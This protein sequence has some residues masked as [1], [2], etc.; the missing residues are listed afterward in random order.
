MFLALLTVAS[1]AAATPG[2]AAQVQLAAA[3][4]SIKH[5]SRDD[6]LQSIYKISLSPKGAAVSNKAL[7]QLGYNK[8]EAAR[9]SMLAMDIA[10][11]AGSY[12]GFVAVIDGN[13][14]ANV[15]LS[16]ADAA[17]LRPLVARGKEA[18]KLHTAWDGRTWEGSSNLHVA[19]DGRTWEGSAK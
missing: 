19:W 8:D 3:T 15:K 6:L 7:M 11:M 2:L 16:S 18:A 4:G 5:I 12:K 1:A 10:T 17:L 9:L 13:A 14:P